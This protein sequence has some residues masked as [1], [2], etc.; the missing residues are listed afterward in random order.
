MN[1]AAETKTEV[2]IENVKPMEPQIIRILDNNGICIAFACVG[3]N[4]TT[5]QIGLCQDDRFHV[6]LNK[7]NE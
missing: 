5:V 7:E 3:Y 1:I 2:K 4:S 6:E